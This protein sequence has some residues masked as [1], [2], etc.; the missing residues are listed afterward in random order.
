MITVAKAAQRRQ[1]ADPGMS[2]SHYLAGF[3]TLE[4]FQEKDLHPGTTF[5]NQADQDVEIVTYV[6]HGS[7]TLEDSV[8]R[9]FALEA[10][11]IHR[12]SVRGGTLQRG[13]NASA[14]DPARVV[15][16]FITPDRGVLQTPSEKKRFPVAERRGI[17]RLVVSRNG[18]QASLRIRQDVG[19]YSSMLDRG[20]H[21]IHELGAGRGAWLAVLDGRIQVGE[22]AL[23]RGDAAS[24][25]DEAAVSL[26]AQDRA[27]ILLFDLR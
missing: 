20:H 22:Q 18:H 12:A 23:E 14:S 15:Q 24:F 21:L 5:Q 17:L 2:T 8:G 26:T 3:R 9:A 6:L 27:E 11:E 10:G 1:Q 13:S 4:S 16:G 7:I 19:G 25:V